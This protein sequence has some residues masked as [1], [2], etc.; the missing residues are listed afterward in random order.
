M[1]EQHRLAVGIA[2]LLVAQ[3]VAVTDIKHVGAVRLDRGME[4]PNQWFDRSCHGVIL[5]R[6]NCW[7]AS[8]RLRSL[9]Q[10]P[11]VIL[12][13]AQIHLPRAGVAGIAANGPIRRLFLTKR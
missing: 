6:Q 4:S 13:R 12:S 5:G 9:L 10:G 1:Q 8:V 2:G 7:R 11:G 3:A